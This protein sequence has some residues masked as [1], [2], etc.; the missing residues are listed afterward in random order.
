MRLLDSKI[1]LIAT[2]RERSKTGTTGQLA[3]QH[4]TFRGSVRR[5]CRG[6]LKNQICDSPCKPAQFQNFVV[7]TLLINVNG[8]RSFMVRAGAD[9]KG[10]IVY[11]GEGNMMILSFSRNP[12]IRS[13]GHFLEELRTW[14]GFSGFAVMLT[15]FQAKQVADLPQVVHVTPDSLYELTI[16][17]TW[18]Y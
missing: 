14:H 9:R 3:A 15:K 4:F 10:H 16:T 11:F 7:L 12:I 1:T 6:Y 13:C 8:E 5:Y 2:F 17:R 18:D